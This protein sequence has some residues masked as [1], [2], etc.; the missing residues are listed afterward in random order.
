MYA[1]EL[2]AQGLS[3]EVLNVGLSIIDQAQVERGPGRIWQ[4]ERAAEANPPPSRAA[5]ASMRCATC[6]ASSPRWRRG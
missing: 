4:R 2:V 6:W 3:G 5:T 1:R